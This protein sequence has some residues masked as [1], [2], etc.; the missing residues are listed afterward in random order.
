MKINRLLHSHRIFRMTQEQRAKNLSKL[1]GLSYQEC[2]QR[3][4]DWCFDIE[5]LTAFANLV[6]QHQ[7]EQYTRI[8][9]EI[10]KHLG[11][12]SECAAAIRNQ[13]EA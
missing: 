7:K 5:G 3:N 11:I 9:D 13:N 4:G 12:A 6:A 10:E 1:S 2:L 8:C